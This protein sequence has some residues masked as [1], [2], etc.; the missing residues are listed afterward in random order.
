MGTFRILL[1]DDEENA[2]RA[3]E[4]MINKHLPDFEIVGKTTSAIEA[5]SLINDL[6]PDVLM[7][8][9]NMPQIDGFELLNALTFRQFQLVIV[10]AH[11][12]YASE[13]FNS[14]AVHYLLKPVWLPELIKMAE[15]IRQRNKEALSIEN[16]SA[17]KRIPIKSIDHVEYVYAD[18]II[19]IVS[20]E[21]YS[22]IVLQK[23][24]IISTKSLKDYERLID[25]PSII[26]VHNSYLINLKYVRKFYSQHSEIELTNG[27]KIPLSRRNKDEFLK[28]ME[29]YG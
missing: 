15:K 3:M 8:D 21:G 22:K 9:I 18:E 16:F 20:D 6:Q 1:V 10:S 4:L 27:Q 13:A 7:L 29:A 28:K 2:I 12:H 11:N 17:R 25:E 24:F 14:N 5:V 26:R 23:H 19:L